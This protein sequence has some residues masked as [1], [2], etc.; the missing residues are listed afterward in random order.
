M[1]KKK[2]FLYDHPTMQ[3]GRLHTKLF[4]LLDETIQSL[5]LFLKLL[6]LNKYAM[7]D[8]AVYGLFYR[9]SQPS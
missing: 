3:V 8:W 9:A 2:Y 1:Y 4:V 5:L 6:Q 7:T